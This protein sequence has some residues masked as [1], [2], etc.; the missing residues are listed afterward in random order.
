MQ[1]ADIPKKRW[2]KELLPLLAEGP[3]RFVSQQGLVSSEHG[4]LGCSASGLGYR[5]SH[6]LVHG[7]IVRV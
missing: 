5:R 7:L 6:E 4:Q 2:T 1:Q 3:F